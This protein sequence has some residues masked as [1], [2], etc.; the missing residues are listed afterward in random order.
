MNPSWLLKRVAELEKGLVM[1]ERLVAAYQIIVNDFNMR[2]ASKEH[3]KFLKENN[4]SMKKRL[5][6]LEAKAELLEKVPE[7]E[8][9]YRSSW[10]DYE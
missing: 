7:L 3:H 6:K 4:I 2:G 8:I 1:Q 9:A 5:K 10:E